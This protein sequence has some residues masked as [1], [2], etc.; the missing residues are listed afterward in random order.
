MD[1]WLIKLAM[2]QELNVI[3]KV[4]VSISNLTLSGAKL[5]LTLPSVLLLNAW[6]NVQMKEMNVFQSH[7]SHAL[8]PPTG[9]TSGLATLT[10]A[11]CIREGVT[12]TEHSEM[13]IISVSLDAENFDKNT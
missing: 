10:I 11:I 3:G 4:A 1:G 13:E 6:N 8:P 9:K 5:K 2:H 7:I 12:K